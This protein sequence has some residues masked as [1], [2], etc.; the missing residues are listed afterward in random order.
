MKTTTNPAARWK[1]EHGIIPFD[2]ASNSFDLN[3]IEQIWRIMKQALRK[4]RAEIHSM[5]DYI[6]AIQERWNRIPLSKIN[7]LVAR[8][9]QLLKMQPPH[10]R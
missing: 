9:Q 5:Q 7:E 6:I 1:R 2:W 3:P 8:M 4:R 10:L